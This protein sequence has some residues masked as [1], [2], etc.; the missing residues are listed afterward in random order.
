MKIYYLTV[1]IG[2]FFTSAIAQSED[3]YTKYD[4]EM[5][6]LA[7][8][9]AQ[10]VKEKNKIKVA[11]WGFT[12][13]FGKKTD[14]GDYIAR[15]F[16][17]HFTNEGNSFEVF[18][19]DHLAQYLQEHQLNEEGFINPQTAKQIGMLTAADAIITG[20]V[21]VG[22]HHLRI[23]LKIINTETGGQIAAALRNIYI[24]QNITII[25]E[26]IG[27]SRPV[28]PKIK[29]TPNPR[30]KGNDPRT[31]DKECATRNTGD[32]CFANNSNKSYLIDIRGKGNNIRRSI[33]IEI[34]QTECINGL[35]EGD[36]SYSMYPNKVRALLQDTKGS[37]R[38]RACESVTKNIINTSYNDRNKNGKSKNNGNKNISIKD[39]LDVI[40]PIFKKKN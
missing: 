28:K 18:D 38:V 22:L 11:I 2:I 40:E 26:D 27:F 15:D 10:K 3:G 20:T 4:K 19:R 23:R 29:V 13:S 32:Y 30:E 14:L 25:L 7:R 9:V 17:I 12:N 24:D 21:D 34:S 5:I 39:V 36:Y 33:T 8:E 16:S 35:P 1:L 37:F 31:T 6:S